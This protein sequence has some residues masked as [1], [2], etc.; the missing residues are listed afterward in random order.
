MGMTMDEWNRN[1]S[2]QPDSADF[3]RDDAN[4]DGKRRLEQDAKQKK[5]LDDALD[6]GL[7]ES[8][9]GSDPVSV[10]QPPQSAHDKPKR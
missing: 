9:P 2:L 6:R 4:R 1:R 8:F 3:E 7:E 10:T 5:K